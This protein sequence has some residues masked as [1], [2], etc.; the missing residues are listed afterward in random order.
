MTDTHLDPAKVASRQAALNGA[1]SRR[2]VRRIARHRDPGV[3]RPERLMI[4]GHPHPVL[5]RTAAPGR[6]VVLQV[7]GF[8]DPALAAARRIGGQCPISGAYR[9]GRSVGCA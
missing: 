8:L 3:D 5:T 9:T 2:A 1:R 4:G 7:H 6:P